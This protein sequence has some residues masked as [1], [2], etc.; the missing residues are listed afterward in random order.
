[1]NLKRASTGASTDSDADEAK[2]TPHG[3]ERE[4]EGV[5]SKHKDTALAWESDRKAQDKLAT[6]KDVGRA[7]AGSQE[8]EEEEGEVE[9]ERVS[10]ATRGRSDSLLD[11]QVPVDV[12]DSPS[13]KVKDESFFSGV[14]DSDPYSVT[15]MEELERLG[16]GEEDGGETSDI[17]FSTPKTSNKHTTVSSEH[18]PTST[19]P[20]GSLEKKS[21]SKGSGKKVKG[22]GVMRPRP[23]SMVVSPQAEHMTRAW[24]ED[25]SQRRSSLH[26]SEDALHGKV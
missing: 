20:T 12:K 19:T 7:N 8:V 5:A 23:M 6:G 10:T 15:A 1:M 25:M 11:E 4:E 9:G 18:T 24:Q 26:L 22:S 14:G 21:G 13:L 3:K 2:T 17:S 16:E